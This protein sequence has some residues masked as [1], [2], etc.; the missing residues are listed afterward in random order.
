M[1]YVDTSGNEGSHCGGDIQIRNE[2][3]KQESYKDG[4]DLEISV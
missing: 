3:D 4:Q 2:R 1:S